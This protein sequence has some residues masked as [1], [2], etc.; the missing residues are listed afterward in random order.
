[1][2]VTI[3]KVQICYVF[4]GQLLFERVG[5]VFYRLPQIVLRTNSLLSF[6][7]QTLY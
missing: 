6:S 3:Y 7:A 2:E 1:M 5:I 4:L